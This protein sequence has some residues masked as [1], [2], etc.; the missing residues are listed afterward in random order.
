VFITDEIERMLLNQ[1]WLNLGYRA[2]KYRGLT[3]FT[4]KEDLSSSKTM[5]SK[6]SDKVVNLTRE[7]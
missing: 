6:E 4:I 1:S 5:Y 3:G 7:E 2:H